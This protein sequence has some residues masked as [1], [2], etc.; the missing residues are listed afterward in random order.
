V[1]ILIVVAAVRP[2]V[3]ETYHASGTAM[4]AVLQAVSDPSPLRTLGF[5]LAI[6]VA[7][8]LWLAGRAAGPRRRYRRTGLAGGAAIIAIAGCVSCVFAGN[9]RVAITAT[10]DWLCGPILAIVLVQVMS[11]SWHRRL[12]L[13]VVAATATAQAVE[14]FHQ[15]FVAFEDTR[16]DYERRKRDGFWEKQGIDPDAPTVR[17]FEAR[18]NAREA[19]GFLVH[20]NVAGAYLV[21]CGLAV[22]GTAAT[23]WSPHR[24][25][26]RHGAD[27][28]AA[29]APPASARPA[30]HAAAPL[31]LGVVFVAA[32]VLTKSRG[33]LVA[34][35]VGVALW[36]AVTLAARWM[37][38]HRGPVLVG[39]WCLVA[40]GAVGVVGYGVRHGSLPG[41]SLAFRWQYWQASAHLIA[42]HPWTGVGRDNFGAHY[43]RYKTI[44]S[45]EEITNP[46]NVLVQAAAEWGV[47]GCVGMIVIM[48][49]VSRRLNRPIAA[50]LQPPETYDARRSR[51]RTI[52]SG[53][54]VA[55]AVM[56]LRL[57]LLGS[58]NPAYA[59]FTTVIVAVPWIVGFAAVGLTAPH[60]PRPDRSDTDPST[61]AGTGLVVGLFA[62]MLH[63]MIS[64]ALFVPGAA[65]TFFA[66]L[67][68]AL[69]ERSAA[70]TDQP[71]P[72]GSQPPG[73]PQPTTTAQPTTSRH[74][75]PGHH[76]PEPRHRA[77]RL[78][79]WCPC[80]G[81]VAGVVVV[82]LVFV[83][84]VARSSA[85][86]A[87]ARR[88]A[89]TPT[90]DPIERHPAHQAYRA[91]TAADPL[92]PTPPAEHARWWLAVA[93]TPRLRDHALREAQ[94]AID[95]AIARDPVGLRHRRQR[96]RILRALAAHTGRPTDYRAAVHAARD[97]LTLYPRNPLG[98]IALGDTL[99][100][101]AN[102]THDPALRSEAADAYRNALRLDDARPAWETFRRLS[103]TRRDAIQSN[104]DTAR[105]AP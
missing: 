75:D 53:A 52:I 88:Y 67:A 72:P 4:D 16:Q 50:T 97:A 29:R 89:A 84:P 76:D 40:V 61:T 11:R 94:A 65:V 78:A 60:A 70:R 71:H 36:L 93:Q 101:A 12:L 20:S 96:M 15:H 95:R 54:I 24:P 41:A 39:G 81:A 18:M 34:G 103:D 8:C 45:P 38:A 66:L 2:L 90:T 35:G 48:I 86:L 1:V 100:D 6:L 99:L 26:P 17:L 30:T 74:G 5:D 69:A 64:F 80:A 28:H 21:L 68:C 98:L 13:A 37:R 32:A 9:Q 59:Y 22:L 85:E 51:R 43:L 42:D 62:F 87:R 33:A 73:R 83:R 31:I 19:S 27:P 23:R 102:A 56:T 79:A 92:D 104:I 57:V 47:P 49:A 77:A 58:S 91:A 7:A 46:H 82:A 63:D 44:D 105:R 25:P 55:I 3:A 10:I 14:C